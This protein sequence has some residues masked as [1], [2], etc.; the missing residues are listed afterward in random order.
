MYVVILIFFFFYSVLQASARRFIVCVCCTILQSFKV[1]MLKSFWPLKSQIW[2]VYWHFVILAHHFSHTHRYSSSGNTYMSVKMVAKVILFPNVLHAHIYNSSRMSGHFLCAMV[3]FLSSPS[4][5][6][7]IHTSWCMLSFHR[8]PGSAV[9]HISRRRQNKSV[10][11]MIWNV[12]T[13]TSWS[14][15]YSL[16]RLYTAITFQLMWL[17]IA[18]V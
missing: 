4:G 5:A 8:S 13:L 1:L 14:L 9:S 6:P 7:H 18:Q 16:S 3:L 10:W 17:L 12:H 15:V 2:G 11:V